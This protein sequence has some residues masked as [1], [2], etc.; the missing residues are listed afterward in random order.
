MAPLGDFITPYIYFVFIL[1]LPFN[2]S[3]TWLLIIAAFYGMFFDFLMITPG[4]HASACLLVAYLRPFLLNLLL[5]REVKE[6]NYAEPS[7]KSMGFAPYAVYSVTLILVHH[8]Y[9]ILLQWMSVGSFSYFFIKLILTT[10]TSVVLVGIM[11]AII[12]RK[13]KTRASLQ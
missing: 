7:I 12:L 9:L 4:I 2:I 8:S 5:A 1:W 6:M 10:L 13:Q 3:R 11:E